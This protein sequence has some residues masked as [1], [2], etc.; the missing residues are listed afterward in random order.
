[1]LTETGRVITVADG[2]AMI[3]IVRG[4]ACDK[5]TSECALKSGQQCLLIEARDPVG[6]QKHDAVQIG[7]PT[8]SLVRASAVV[9][10]LP[11]LA[12]VFGAILGEYLA[13]VYHF[14]LKS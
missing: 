12:L 1:M 5:C 14:F 2:K 8:T 9:Y 7:M 6:V 3:E 10:M 13:Q 4:A 11:L